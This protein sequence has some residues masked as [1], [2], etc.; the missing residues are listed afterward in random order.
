[1]KSLIKKITTKDEAE[2]VIK[3]ATL[4]LYILVGLK[5]LA[6]IVTAH[7]KFV[8]IL[9]ELLLITLLRQYRSRISGFALT[10]LFLPPLIYQ[11]QNLFTP[12]RELDIIIEYLICIFLSIRASEAALKFHGRFNISPRPI[13]SI[14]CKGYCRPIISVG[15]KVYWWF[16]LLMIGYFSY[17]LY[18]LNEAKIYDYIDLPFTIFG[19]VG[20][21]GYAYKK[22]IFNSIVWKWSFFIIIFWETL[23]SI[24]L[25]DHQTVNDLSIGLKTGATIFIYAFLLPYYIALYLYG[26]KSDRIWNNQLA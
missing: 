22:A 2:K 4:A 25:Y 14:R 23:Y 1:M 18:I 9:I 6:M 19:L 11:T 26:Y 5:L 13:I 8:I 10:V 17:D 7:H 21:F 20:L 12:G 16:L 15:Y 24:F 3:D